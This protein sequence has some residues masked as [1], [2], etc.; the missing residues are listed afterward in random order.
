MTTKSPLLAM[1]NDKGMVLMIRM[2]A[3]YRRRDEEGVA[4]SADFRHIFDKIFLMTEDEAVDILV[5]AIEF[6]KDD[7]NFPGPTMKKIQLLVQGSKAVGLETTDY[8]FDLKAEAAIIHY[9]SP[10]PEVRSVTDAFDDPTIP[11]E[12]FRSYFLGLGWMAGATAVNTFFSPRQPAISIGSSVLQLLLAPCGLFLA[13]VLPDWGVTVF[14][15]RHSLNPGPWSYKEQMFATIIF[16]VGNGAGGTYYVYLAQKLPQ[17]L[18]QKWVTFAYEIVLALS[19][20]FFRFGF[21]GLLRRFV[22][23]PITAIWPKV[24]PTLAL[25]RA[26]VIPDRKGEVVNGWKMTRYR[27]F[28]AAFAAMFLYFWIPNFL[29][30]ALHSFN[31]MTWIA[32]QNFQFGY[33]HWLLRW[34]GLQPYCYF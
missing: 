14:G 6:H 19:I 1:C 28:L 34:V 29:F 7:R 15:T 31:W 9:H 16:N 23:Y 26:L 32:P 18:D 24:I 33:D 25:N 8:D 2:A 10:Y 4:P 5:K 13:R 3:F 20:Q 11:V 12:T 22:I 17:Y 21:A 27:F 30:T